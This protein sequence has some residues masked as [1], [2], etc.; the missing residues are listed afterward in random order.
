MKKIIFLIFLLFIWA[1]SLWSGSLSTGFVEILIQNLQPGKSCS[2]EKIAKYPYKLKN[3]SNKKIKV[4]VQAKYS[5]KKY[6]REKFNHIPDINWVKI[7]PKIIEIEPGEEGAADIIINIPDKEKYYNKRYQVNILAETVNIDK[8]RKAFRIG[9]ALE[10]VLLFTTLKKGFTIKHSPKPI[11]LNY[12]LIP[13]HLNITNI[14]IKNTH[15]LIKKDYELK[16][17]NSDTNDINLNVEV[18]KVS[19]TLAQ[20]RRGYEDIHELSMIKL[21]TR[22]IFLKK[23]EQGIIKFQFHIYD[24]EIFKNKKYQFVLN[25]YNSKDNKASG[26]YYKVYLDL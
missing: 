18:L 19:N 17:I 15:K 12:E 6:L 1:I 8:N 25:I 9:L 11:N 26:K 24:K 7:M 14:Q 23:G 22:T 3:K 13:G 5:D 10:S 20:L 21:Q 2:L 16:V 4:R